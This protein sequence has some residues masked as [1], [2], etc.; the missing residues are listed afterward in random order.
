MRI[1]L[2]SL[3]YPPLG[4]EGVARQRQA[5]AEALVL[6]GHDVHVVTLGPTREREVV[7]GVHVH[8]YRRGDAVNH[9]LPD[10]PVLDAPLTDAQLLCE[11]VLDVASSVPLEIVDVPLWLAQPL[12]LVRYAPCPVVVWLQTSLLQLIEMQQREARPHERVLAEIDRYTIDRASACIADSR[13][14]AGEIARLYARPMLERKTTVV[15]PGLPDLRGEAQPP[16]S[17][18]NGGAHDRVEALVVGRLEQRKGTHLLFDALPRLLAASPGLHIRFV[19]RDNSTSDG[20]KRATGRTYPEAMQDRYPELATR[21][22]FDG[23]VD[24]ATLAARYASADVLVHPAIYE[25]FGLIFIEAMRAARPTV[26]FAGGGATEV[27][28]SGERDG[29]VL[30]APGDV[31]GF[32]AA[33]SSVASDRARRIRL[34]SAARH[35]YE[36]SFTSELMARET[37][38]V[39]ARVIERAAPTKGTAP[40]NCI[41]RRAPR[42]FQVMEALQGRDAVSGIART[43]AA[44]L[45]ELGAERPIMALFADATVRSETGRLRGARFQSRDAAIFHYWGFSRLEQ[46]I[47]RFPGRKAIHY[48]NITP[49]DFFAG[50]SA[51]YEMTTRGYAQ[52]ARIA[53]G[54]D[55]AIGDSNY[56]LD[57][58]AEHLTVVKPTVCIYPGISPE[59]LQSAAWDRATH[60]RIVSEAEGPV[61]LFVGRCAPNKRQDLVMQAFDRFASRG[62]RRLRPGRLLLVGDMTSV[63]AY[64]ERLEQLRATLECGDRITFVPSAPDEQLRAYYRAANLFVCASEHEGFC[65]PV[66]EAMAFSLPVIALDRGAVGEALGRAGVL[67]P[68][69]HADE[70]ARLAEELLEDSSRREVFAAARQERLRE[71]SPPA[72]RTRLEAVIG[73][74]RDGVPSALFVPRGPRHHR[75]GAEMVQSIGRAS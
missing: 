13:S 55:L 10:L 50:R 30:C 18:G 41:P 70:I 52:L 16:R 17:A 49:P 42:V 74:L 53:D 29:A 68:E 75:R 69:W 24:E 58:Y 34:G 63:P 54:F 27:F 62:P 72:I 5:L 7:G 51:H 40:T 3:D 14:I 38:D 19:G 60:A 71:F 39:Y 11:G 46:T 61:W 64:V 23:Y 1:A 21:V 8:R 33:V 43:N 59:A 12:A 36:L 56:N 31:E 73:F 9:F 6:L 20:F 22:S 26:A 32:I 35:A 25:S 47:A 66:A 15:Y 45:A 44:A 2:V 37:A 28:S 65:V 57:A 67:V 48:H 4:T